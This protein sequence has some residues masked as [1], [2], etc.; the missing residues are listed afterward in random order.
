MTCVSYGFP[1]CGHLLSTQSKDIKCRIKSIEAMLNQR[2]QDIDFR[3]KMKEEGKA[4]EV[5]QV[6]TLKNKL[7]R[8]KNSIS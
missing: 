8:Y 6:Q 7:E 5:G 1:D 4:V 3:N 2:K